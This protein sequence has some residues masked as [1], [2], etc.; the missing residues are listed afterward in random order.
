MGEKVDHMP[1]VFLMAGF[2]SQA[3]ET[4]EGTGNVIVVTYL[5]IV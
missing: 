4:M 3:T 5:S 1:F 2:L